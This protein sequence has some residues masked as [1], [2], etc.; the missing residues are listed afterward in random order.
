MPTAFTEHGAVMA[1][2]LLN[3]REAIEV[4]IYVV[5]AFVALR[6]AAAAHEDLA[7]R[8]AELETRVRGK[9]AAHE[10]VLTEILDAL[11]SLTRPPQHEQR[12]IGFVHP[13]D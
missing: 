1:A 8:I 3:S 4:S 10:R 9:F 6:N 2:T 12:P 5:R 11:K 13:A 7:S